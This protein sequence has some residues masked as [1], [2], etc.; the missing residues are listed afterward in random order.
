[1][2]D[3]DSLLSVIVG[4]PVGAL[5]GYV[6]VKFSAPRDKTKFEA[7]HDAGRKE[8]L[9]EGIEAMSEAVAS[10]CNEKEMYF[11]GNGIAQRREYKVG[12]ILDSAHAIVDEAYSQ[13][14]TPE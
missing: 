10:F 7:G 14:S 5:L 8:G 3:L 2:S 11:Q 12:E 9:E 6:A 1:M 4:I 13:E